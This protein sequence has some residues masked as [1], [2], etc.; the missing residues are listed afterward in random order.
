MTDTAPVAGCTV[1]V[2]AAAELLPPQ[3]PTTTTTRATDADLEPLT[4]T[5]ADDTEPFIGYTPTATPILS[6]TPTPLTVT[7]VATDGT[8]TFVA[9]TNPAPTGD[10]T[11]DSPPCSGSWAQRMHSSI[12]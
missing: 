5:L 7:V 1:N 12:A 9:E 4:T 11:P 2:P 6:A 8:P 3:F 10:P